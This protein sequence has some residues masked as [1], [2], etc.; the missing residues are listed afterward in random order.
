[1]SS[2]VVEKCWERLDTDSDRATRRRDRATQD[3]GP[4]PARRCKRISEMVASPALQNI[5]LHGPPSS[6]SQFSS[7]LQQ[8]Y[9]GGGRFPMPQTCVSL[10]S[11]SAVAVLINFAPAFKHTRKGLIRSYQT[12]ANHSATEYQRLFCTFAGFAAP[13]QYYTA[14]YDSDPELFVSG[15]QIVLCI[16]SCTVAANMW[17]LLAPVL[18]RPLETAFC[19]VWHPCCGLAQDLRKFLKWTGKQLRSKKHPEAINMDQ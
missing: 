10:G 12:I 3:R 19:L 13:W 6:I 1:V 9:G 8:Q 14:F 7:S 2:I 16:A 5:G 15:P 17:G 11:I 18:V 4:R